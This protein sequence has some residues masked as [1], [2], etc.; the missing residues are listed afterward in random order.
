MKLF[1]T[2]FI[3]ALAINGCGDNPTSKESETSK[4][5]QTVKKEEVPKVEDIVQDI[6]TLT[7]SKIEETKELI[8]KQAPQITKIVEEKVKEVKATIHEATAPNKKAQDL[9]KTCKG[10]HGPNANKKALGKSAI[11][12]GWSED[13]IYDAL[14]GYKNGTYGAAMKG[15]MVGQV[16]SLSNSDIKELARYISKF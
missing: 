2:L 15:V 7:S 5:I 3:I 10:C 11:I 9:Y 16:K 4:P 13:R 6:K 8:E 14:V 1:L 12:K